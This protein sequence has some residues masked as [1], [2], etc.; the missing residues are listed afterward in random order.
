MNRKGFCLSQLEPIVF[1]PLNGLTRSLQRTD[2]IV[3]WIRNRSFCQVL[4]SG[5]V[6]I[7]HPDIPVFGSE[8]E[9]VG[10]RRLFLG[11]FRIGQRVQAHHIIVDQI[12]QLVEAFLRGLQV[13]DGRDT[14]AV[15]LQRIGK[16]LQAVFRLVIRIAFNGFP[17]E[18]NAG[19]PILGEKGQL[20]IHLF[21]II[22]DIVR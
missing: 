4:R 18:Q 16:S 1:D 3:D 13:F 11:R 22:R 17:I 6:E 2:Q 12:G 14:N 8:H 7:H 9:P 19:D 10:Q 15:F 21:L 5:C 20:L